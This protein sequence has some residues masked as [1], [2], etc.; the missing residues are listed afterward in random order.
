MK[1]LKLNGKIEE[2]SIV[3]KGILR[4]LSILRSQLEN[5]RR[6]R[7]FNK[8]KIEGTEDVNKKPRNGE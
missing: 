5:I 6:S 2:H 3:L 7:S 4:I 8:R 1:N